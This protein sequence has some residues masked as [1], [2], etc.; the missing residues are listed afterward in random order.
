MVFA[1][2]GNTKTNTLKFDVMK[3][4]RDINWDSGVVKQTLKKL[5]W[6]TGN[7]K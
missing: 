4:S 1:S 2:H 5:E 3:L 7:S 6:E